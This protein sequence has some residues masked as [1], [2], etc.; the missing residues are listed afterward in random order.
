[1]KGALIMQ[2]FTTSLHN[3]HQDGLEKQI[4]SYLTTKLP[5]LISMWLASGFGRRL[6]D[7]CCSLS[8]LFSFC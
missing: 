8:A 3:M 6:L 7:V 5:P 1:M 4:A 2:A